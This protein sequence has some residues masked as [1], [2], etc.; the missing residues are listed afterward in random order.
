MRTYLSP[1]RARLL[2]LITLA[3]YALAVGS[4]S[5]AHADAEMLRPAPVLESDHSEQCPTP[6]D[7]AVCRMGFHVE[8]ATS[9]P[10]GPAHEAGAAGWDAETTPA[11]GT[12]TSTS[13]ARGPPSQ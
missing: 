7:D 4:A 13:L 6:H 10:G 2:R 5:V 11:P 8:F 12:P 3:V 1:K 9:L